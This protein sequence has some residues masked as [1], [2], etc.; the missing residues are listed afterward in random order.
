MNPDQIRLG[1]FA[2]VLALF[3]LIESIYSKRNWET[4]RSK[5]ILFHGTVAIFNTFFIRFCIALPLLLLADFVRG[6]EWGL[7]PLLGLKGIPEIVVSIIFLD[8]LDYWWHRWNH[9]VPFFWRFHKV[10]HMDTHVDVT[11]TLRF[12]PGELFLSGMMKSVWILLIGPSIWAFAI[13]EMGISAYAQFHHSNID[14]P[15]RVEK[16]LR[17]IH[18]TPRVHASHHTV[19]PRTRNANYSTIFSI[20]DRLFGTFREHDWDE[21]KT[22]GLSEGRESYLNPLDFLK[23]PFILQ[24][25]NEREKS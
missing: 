3:F 24:G 18:M 25:S 22:L 9:L 15:D 19:T 10:H 20:W 7:M 17:W 23:A 16:I 5:R 14:L 11:T 12:H 13:F 4:P 8:M 21:M 1:I 2:G 6:Q